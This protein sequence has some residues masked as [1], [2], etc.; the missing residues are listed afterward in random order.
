MEFITLKT[1][2]N[3]IDA[4][5]LKSKLESEGIIS[6][7]FDENIVGLNPLYSI[8]VG[9]IKLKINRSDYEKA[10]AILDESIKNKLIDDEG[11]LVHCPKCKS[12]DI[13]SD[14]ISL[15]G[16]K[17]ILAGIVSFLLLVLPFYQNTVYKCKAC[18]FEFKKSG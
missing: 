12:K 14:Y 10:Y 11:E 16:T 8:A 3:P 5:I 15:R 6:F 13:L 9:G 7:L 17:G 2:D 4:H 18:D 1:F